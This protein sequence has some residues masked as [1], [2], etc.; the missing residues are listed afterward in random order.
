VSEPEFP[1]LRDDLNPLSNGFRIIVA[2]LQ[3]MMGTSFHNVDPHLQTASKLLE[4]ILLC[5]VSGRGYPQQHA[6]QVSS[7]AALAELRSTL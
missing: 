6:V 7:A 2:F 5:S 4:F 1:F 3:P